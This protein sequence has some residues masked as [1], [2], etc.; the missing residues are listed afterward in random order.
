MFC[1]AGEGTVTPKISRVHGPLW[2]GVGSGGAYFTANAK[3][4]GM[5]R[6][7]SIGGRTGLRT[8][9]GKLCGRGR[10]ADAIR[11]TATTFA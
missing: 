4:R 7:D 6:G 1:D 2:T 8:N 9:Q 11:Y 10:R 3:V 5:Q